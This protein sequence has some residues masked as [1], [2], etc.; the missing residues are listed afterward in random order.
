MP[1]FQN[2]LITGAEGFIGSHLVE[3]LVAQGRH[4][5][6]MA[7]YNAFGHYGWLDTLPDATRSKIDLVMGDVRDALSVREAMR[8]CDAVMHLA[9]LV[10]IPYSYQAPASY[11]DTNV[12]GTLHV[13]QAAR[14]LGVGKV[15]HTSTSEVYGSARIVPIAETHPLAAQSPYAASKIG[16]DQMAH[17]YYCA[18]GTPVA[19]ARPFNTYGPRQSLRAVLPTIM[20]QALSAAPALRLGALSPTRDFNFV[21]DTVAGLLAILDSDKAVGEVIQLGSGHEVSIGDAVRL[22]AEITGKPLA[23]ETEPARLRPA[24]SEVER[25]VCDPAKA[26]ALLGWQSTLAGRD[27]L[28]QGLT[29]SL[30]WFANPHNRSHYHDAQRYVV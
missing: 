4:V 29:R 5:R 24:A 17:S 28:R 30:E 27:G 12:T 26:R 10:A 13:L 1:P 8:G 25:L 22:I 11:V 9:A 18:F 20:L 3:A 15:V 19:T 6:A 21:T 14:D 23:V 2:I 7:W 16:A